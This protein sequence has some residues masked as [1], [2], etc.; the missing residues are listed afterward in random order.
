MRFHVPFVAALLAGLLGAPLLP[1]Q[2]PMREIEELARRI[3]EQLRDVDKMLLESGQKTQTRGQQKELLKKAADGSTTAEASIDE[4][5]EKLTQMKNQ[6]SSSQS[7]SEKDQ[8]GKQPQG[9]QQQQ[10][11]GQNQNGQQPRR[12]N[13][14]PD[15]VKQKGEQPQPGEQQ[16]QKPQN[17]PGKGDEKGA[18]NSTEAAENRP[19]DRRPES[20]TG[21]K[22]PGQ[23]DESWGELQPYMNR[24]K[25]RGS[26][27]K[28]PEKYRKYW[29][30]NL[31]KKQSEGGK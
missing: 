12:E 11:Q 29:Q 19:G 31:K 2:D 14:T 7:E 1:A 3:D 8:Q 17:M 27:P 23:G 6:S 15:Y 16:Q 13:Q 4:L 9:G 22:N 25:S 24:L 20:E 26:A 28:V 18:E 5:I 21:P 30:A 10:N